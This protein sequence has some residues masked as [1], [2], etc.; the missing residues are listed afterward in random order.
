MPGEQLA[1]QVLDSDLVSVLGLII[2]L[3]VI[4]II[5]VAVASAAMMYY[6]N[7]GISTMAFTQQNM[8][9]ANA[10]W[11][12]SDSKKTAA[13]ERSVEETRM[14]RE[15]YKASNT[16][17]TAAI[18][19]ADH[20]I[21][22]HEEKSDVRVKTI[23]DQ[24]LIGSRAHTDALSNAI[25]KAVTTINAS[26]L[27]TVKPALEALDSL[28]RANDNMST[29]HERTM[30]LL[31][32][33][34]QAQIDFLERQNKTQ[35]DAINAELTRAQQEIIRVLNKETNTHDPLPH[36]IPLPLPFAD[37]DTDPGADEP[38]PEPVGAGPGDAADTRP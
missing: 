26:T 38:V 25:D 33:Q 9:T 11:A 19:K 21:R 24:V 2:V 6:S 12:E 27:E 23:I 35:T 5:I 7:K 4:V 1:Q 18:E 10:R 36:S 13:L 20:D 17:L 32:Q 16:A 31:R 30:E 29:N 15:D 22:D 28:R 37:H 3:L 34:H 8:A 14:L